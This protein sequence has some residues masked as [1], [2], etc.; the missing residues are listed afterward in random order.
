MKTTKFFVALLLA[1]VLMP[2]VL[3]SCEKNNPTPDEPT[4]VVLEKPRYL[5]AAGGKVYAT[6]YAPASV[7]RI[8]TASGRVEDTLMLGTT[9]QPEGIAVAAGRL[10]VAS[11]WIMDERGATLYDHSLYVVDMATFS[12]EQILEVGLNPDRVMT[13][14]DSLV[15][16]C[17]NGDYDG[18]PGNSY[19][20]DA[21]TLAVTAAGLEM[22]GLTVDQGLVYAYSAP[23]G[24]GNV[25]YFTFD[26]A[27]GTTTPI[28]ADCGVARPYGIA[29]VD[30]DVLLTAATASSMGDVICFGPDGERR[31]T[32][33]AGMFT[34]K[35]VS[36]G[37]GT[38]YVLNQGLWGGNDA[39][40]SRV[41]LA[42]G[43]I[44]N[45]IFAAANG[46]GLGDIAQDIL[47]YG[48]KAYITVTFSNTIEVVDPAT[49][50][51]SQIALR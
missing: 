25:S 21:R 10:F 45:Y 33:E 1:T 17:C 51:S 19:L 50:R 8:D 13:V 36:L 47:V 9:F 12:V 22:T 27:S 35:L 43:Q 42:N 37:D 46:R 40:L 32:C 30:G 28:L 5:A 2:V 15:V 26:P 6:C 14:G 3:V 39:S 41:T 20:V 49:N 4:R 7:L 11:S 29:V 18:V 16:V 24:S 44:T 48:S 23:Y 38:A 34:S 31:W